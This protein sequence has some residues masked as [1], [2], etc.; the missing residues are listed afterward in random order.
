MIYRSIKHSLLKMEKPKELSK[1]N[2]E[3]KTKEKIQDLSISYGFK[4]AMIG[5]GILSKYAMFSNIAM[6]IVGFFIRKHPYLQN[7]TD[8]KSSFLMIVGLICLFCLLGFKL[9]Q[10]VNVSKFHFSTNIKTKMI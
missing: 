5:I 4:V 3:G 6:A 1:E 2:T 8:D 7:K 9:V 10:I